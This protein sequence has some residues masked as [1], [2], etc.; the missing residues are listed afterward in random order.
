[1]TATLGSVTETVTV[2]GEWGY[3]NGLEWGLK[4]WTVINNDWNLNYGAG[5]FF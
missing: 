1:L 5:I 2:T 4:G 3:V